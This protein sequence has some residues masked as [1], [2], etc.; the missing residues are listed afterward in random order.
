MIRRQNLFLRIIEHPR[1]EGTHK[2]HRI[3]LLAA[4]RS[5]QTLCLSMLSEIFLNSSSFGAVTSALGSLFHANHSLVK[6]R[7]LTPSPDTSTSGSLRSCRC[8]QRA[9]LSDNVWGTSSLLPQE[10]C[11]RNVA[12]GSAC[13]HAGL[14]MDDVPVVGHCKT[15]CFLCLALCVLPGGALQ[16]P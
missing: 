9:E 5:T 3:Q 12:L 1:L 6:N 8:H 4:H 13:F 10:A 11:Q 15:Y 16:H 2:N 7:F 14:G